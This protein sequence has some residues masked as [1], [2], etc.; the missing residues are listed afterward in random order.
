[1]RTTAAEV[2]TLESGSGREMPT[3]RP[4]QCDYESLRSRT[5]RRPELL[6]PATYTPRGTLVEELADLPLS[7]PQHVRRGLRRQTQVDLGAH[8]YVCACTSE[9]GGV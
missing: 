7:R 5:A 4:S 1:M 6:K 3:R 2:A 8:V 9:F